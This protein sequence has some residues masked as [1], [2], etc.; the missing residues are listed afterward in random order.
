MKRK[1]KLL[2]FRWLRPHHFITIM[3]VCTTLGLTSAYAI[4][5]TTGRVGAL[6]PYISDTG[7]KPPASCV[8]G[9][10]LN[11]SSVFTAV[12]VYI[13]HRQLEGDDSNKNIAVVNDISMF[14]GLLSCIGMMIV[15]C[16]QKTEVLSVHLIGA[17]MVFISGIV[18]CWLQSY[19]SYLTI[20]GR[21]LK[22]ITRVILSIVAVLCITLFIVF[23]KIS[24]NPTRLHWKSHEV[25]YSAFLVSTFCEWILVVCFVLFF[26][27]FYSEFKNTQL[28]VLMN[29]NVYQVEEV[30]L[31]KD[32]ET[33][34]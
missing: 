28:Q 8:F 4:S 3:A 13:R 21:T 1:S 11:L 5:V 19:L 17:L 2:L 16:F 27:T 20:G 29:N 15:A 14:T 22:A 7:T 9:L 25:G 6:F 32:K 24:R 31:D 10:M 23:A 30:L 33:N 26:A 34:V 12:A 18:Y